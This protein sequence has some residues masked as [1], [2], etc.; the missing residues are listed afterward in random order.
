MIRGERVCLRPVERSD[1]PTL[2]AWTNDESAHGAYNMFGLEGRQGLEQ[3]FANTGF[4]DERQGML[5]VVMPAGQPVGS[6][7]YRVVE[8][9]PNRGSQAYAIGISLLADQRGKGYG[10][11][12]Q[13]LLASYLFDTY[14][15]VRVEASTDI[16]NIPEQR[17]LEKAGFTREGVLR[18]T[19]WRAGDWHDLVV[20]S[21][22]RGE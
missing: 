15:I 18:K 6:V 22:L 10:V 11:E 4:L 8:Y 12:A 5:L 20:Y 17:A 19:Q 7:G 16:T 9:G 2:E 14:P 21:K 13:Q 3:G 1:L